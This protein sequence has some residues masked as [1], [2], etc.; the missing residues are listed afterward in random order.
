MITIN[1]K[2][3]KFTKF[4][5]NETLVDTSY[6]STLRGSKENTIIFKYNKD[7]DLLHFKFVLDYLFEQECVT[8]NV[9]ITYMPY[10]RMDRSQ[11][12]S[13]FT[14]K[15]ILSMFKMHFLFNNFYIV[16]P[17]S[18]VSLCEGNIKPLYITPELCKIA[19]TENPDITAICFPDKGAK[20]R[21]TNLFKE[22]YPELNNLNI[23]YCNKTRDFNTGKITGLELVGDT[24][25]VKSVLIA[26]D[27]CSAG[28]TFYYTAQKLKENG[29]ENIFLAITHTENNISNGELIKD[30]TPINKIYTTDSMGS[31]LEYKNIE[32]IPLSEISLYKGIAYNDD[33]ELIKY[34]KN[35]V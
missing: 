10:S 2:E 33:K 6:L 35:A 4:P 16:E 8:N 28:G 1:D 3:I 32:V 5:N 24:T 12:G 30:T 26:D 23:L 19:I 11:N 14:L 29:V 34:I 22:Y 7:E 21:Y 17:H 18:D 31:N 25:D 27:L 9:V 20:K 13:C 15:Y